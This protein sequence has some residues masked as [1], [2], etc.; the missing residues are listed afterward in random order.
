[1][2]PL[3]TASAAQ[4]LNK[5]YPLKT[6][7]A[8]IRFLKNNR[9][10]DRSPAFRISFTNIA[11]D[12]YYLL[13]DLNQFSKWEKFRVKNEISNN[14]YAGMARYNYELTYDK[15]GFK[16]GT[17]FAVLSCTYKNKPYVNLAF[18]TARVTFKLSV[19]EVRDLVDRLSVFLS[20]NEHEPE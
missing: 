13:K 7:E 6:E 17:N 15:I 9:R 19:P 12:A 4:W 20:A 18:H 2:K 3:T 1:M 14:R 5:K 10:N 11:G 8:W 16:Q